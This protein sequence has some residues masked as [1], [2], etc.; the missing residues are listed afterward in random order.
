MPAASPTV[1]TVPVSTTASS[2]Q[3]AMRENR[4]A[5]ITGRARP[6]RTACAAL[7]E[8][9]AAAASP[10]IQTPD[11][12]QVHG[13][14]EL[15]RP[16]GHERGRRDRSWPGRASP[17]P[18][19]CRVADQGKRRRR[20]ARDER[21]DQGERGRREQPVVDAAGRRREQ[22]ADRGADHVRLRERHDDRAD[23]RGDARER[24]QP[25]AAPATRL[26]TP[27]AAVTAVP[28]DERETRVEQRLAR[29]RRAARGRAGS[30]RPR[31]PVAAAPRRLTT[32]TPKAKTPAVGWP[33]ASETT[34]H[35]T[36]YTPSASSSGSVISG[37]AGDALA[38]AR[39]SGSGATGLQHRHRRQVGVGRLGERHRDRG[40]RGREDLPVGGVGRLEPRVRGRGRR[41]P[42][43]SASPRSR[44]RRRCPREA[45]ACASPLMVASVSNRT[46]AVTLGSNG[47]WSA[48]TYS[49]CSVC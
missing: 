1:R 12:E 24:Q 34:T 15:R 46:A 36:V 28:T 43:R 2:A 47:A 4:F 7:D 49:A 18:P 14:R 16:G 17:P 37:N 27:R 25:R 40:R 31:P 10:P 38:G 22:V 42:R 32:P 3:P 35:E 23:E 19:R 11:G 45:A 26:R 21:R 5:S 9:R 41:E 20:P 13:L 30:R 8:Q 48:A 44:R 39:L 6:P 29:D 33:S